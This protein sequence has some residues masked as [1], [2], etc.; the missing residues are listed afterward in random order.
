MAIICYNVA[1]WTES[2]QYV[3]IFLHHVLHRRDEMHRRWLIS[4]PS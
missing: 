1:S 2:V 4:V 3:S